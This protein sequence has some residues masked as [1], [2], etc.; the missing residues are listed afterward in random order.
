MREKIGGERKGKERKRKQG[1]RVSSSEVKNDTYGN[2]YHDNGEF[3]RLL[4]DRRP[5]YG[6]RQRNIHLGMDV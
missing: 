5:L 6:Y 2:Y 1:K 4:F 3:T